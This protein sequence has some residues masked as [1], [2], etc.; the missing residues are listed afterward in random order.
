MHTFPIRRRV[1]FGGGAFLIP[2]SLCLPPCCASTQVAGRSDPTASAVRT[3]RQEPQGTAWLRSETGTWGFGAR[4]AVFDSRSEFEH[5]LVAASAP[6]GSRP[7]VFVIDAADWCTQAVLTADSDE[8]DFGQS[9]CFATDR[10][11]GRARVI[12]GAPGR[13]AN[14]GAVSVWDARSGARLLTILGDSAGFGFAVASHPDANGDSQPDVLVGEP[15]L[16]QAMP[17]PHGGE[18]HLLCGASGS[19]IANW[20]APVS[21]PRFGSAVE[22]GPDVNGDDHCELAVVEPRSD[23]D[24]GVRESGRIWVMSLRDC[25]FSVLSR[26]SPGELGSG[27]LTAVAWMCPPEADGRPELA[28]LVSVPWSSRWDGDRVGDRVAM[29]RFDPVTGLQTSAHLGQSDN[30]GGSQP[31]VRAVRDWDLA[32]MDAPGGRPRLFMGMGRVRDGSHS[33][34]GLVGA[35]TPGVDREWR[36]VASTYDLPIMSNPKCY[37]SSVCILP[38][39][40]K[41]GSGSRLIVGVP[42]YGLFAGYVAVLDTR[43]FKAQLLVEA[44]EGHLEFSRTQ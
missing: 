21:S 38:D 39:K 6:F 28:A 42:D 4:T 27:L 29:L 35:V 8:R 44:V 20:R 15:I 9:V 3:A 7:K 32:I 37:G 26:A 23:S 24:A 30:W 43:T 16:P 11:G 34:S 41:Q 33:N 14:R 2:V 10:P 18:V 36:T 1:A 5:P 25:R 22:V 17:Q 19:R 13:G 40:S 12:V 31:D